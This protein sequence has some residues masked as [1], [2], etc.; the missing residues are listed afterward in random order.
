VLNI[1][2]QFDEQGGYS[3]AFLCTYNF[4]PGFFEDRVLKTKA[5]RSCPYIAIL[6]DETKY[7][8]LCHDPKGGR[9]INR[10]YMLVPVK[11]PQ[12][13]TGVFHPKL[14]FLSGKDHVKL[15]IGS[16][17]LSRSGITSNLEMVSSFSYIKGDKNKAPIKLFKSA[18]DF[19]QAI[20]IR[21]CSYSDT[22]R[23]AVKQLV[24]LSPALLEKSNGEG[25]I[26]I[27]HNLERP[28]LEQFLT[29]HEFTSAKLTVLGPYFDSNIGELLDVISNKIPLSSIDIV[30][31][32]NTNTLA[33]KALRQ[34]HN[35][36]STNLAIHLLSAPGRKLHAKALILESPDGKECA[37]LVGSAN[38]TKPALLRTSD[39]DGNIELCLAIRGDMAQSVRKSM[40]SEVFSTQEVLLENVRSSQQNDNW[41]APDNEIKLYHAE[42]DSHASLIKTVCQADDKVSASILDFTLLV[43]KI[44]S[45]SPDTVCNI[46]ESRIHKG[47]L[48]FSVGVEDSS[49]LNKATTVAIHAR[50][51]HGE[52]LSNYVWLLNITEIHEYLDRDHIKISRQFR[53]SGKGLIEF[54]NSYVEQGMI[55]KAIKL[56]EDLDIRFNNGGRGII[57]RAIIRMPSSPITDDDA[58]ELIWRLTSGQRGEFAQRVSDFI[59][60]H[61]EKVLKRH[62]KKPN[63]NGLENFFDVLETC[64]DLGITALKNGIIAPSEVY[65]DLL[66]GFQLFSG[67]NL[68]EGYFRVLWC[69]F[70]DVK[71]RL[72]EALIRHKI[73]ERTVA[74]ALLLKTIDTESNAKKADFIRLSDVL[75]LTTAKYL[76]ACFDLVGF[77]TDFCERVAA[78]LI[79]SYDNSDYC[80]VEF[81]PKPKDPYFDD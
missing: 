76:D 53:Q 44:G 60:R 43:R 31:Q 27:I 3:H 55:D 18:Y 56:L 51:P 61:Y 45:A 22:L 65:S 21:H 59:T 40:Q 71:D 62:I 47:H 63:L 75:N 9:L 35:G 23:Q 20:A 30:V 6:I 11:M 19:L 58:T 48:D 34:W 15:F 17:N 80:R 2:E 64:A 77:D 72:R 68:T 39:T 25:E 54:I 67:N 26:D 42:L 8:E 28:M 57:T 16:S 50:T 4:A 73:P 69:K 14:W 1:M 12:S 79:E 24:A 70:Y 74:Y 32:Q 7:Q 52:L 38:F 66:Y 13:Q 10:R 29:H 46:A 33:S 36:T 78:V 81:N 37:S 41:T 49:I 5:F